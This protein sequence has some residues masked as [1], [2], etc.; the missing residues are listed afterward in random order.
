MRAS[1]VILIILLCFT[2]NLQSAEL[3][4]SKWDQGSPIFTQSLST[5]DISTATEYGF[6]LW[7]KYYYRIPQKADVSLLV[8]YNHAIAGVTERDNYMS[9]EFIKD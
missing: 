3:K 4:E 6:G 1:L 8:N 7:F 5:G 9:T 2:T